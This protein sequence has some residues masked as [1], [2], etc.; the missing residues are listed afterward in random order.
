MAKAVT[1]RR[2]QMELEAEFRQDGEAPELHKYHRQPRALPG[3][4]GGARQRALHPRSVD[5]PARRIRVL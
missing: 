3:R 4:S 5:R 1:L 2:N